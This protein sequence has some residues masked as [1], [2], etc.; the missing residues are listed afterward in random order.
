MSDRYYGRDSVLG[1]GVESTFGTAVTITNWLEPIEFTPTETVTNYQPQN[2]RR[3]GGFMI[4][5]PQVTKMEYT[6]SWSGEF[7][8][9]F[10]GML[11]EA[12]MGNAVSTSGAGPYVHVYDP[13]DAASEP[14]KFLTVEGG[15]GTSGNSVLYRGTCVN[16]FA[17]N[18]AP[19]ETVKY[20][21]DCIVQQANDAASEGT[22]TYGA[23]TYVNDAVDFV[24]ATWNGITLS[25][26]ELGSI[27]VTLNN[28]LQPSFALGSLYTNIPFYSGDGRQVEVVMDIQYA[29]T[30]GNALRD[31]NKAGTQSDL[32]IQYTSGAN[33]VLITVRNAFV[34]SNSIPAVADADDMRYSATFR[35]VSDTTDPA[36]T[37]QVTNASSS[38]I[39]NA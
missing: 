39:A 16:T 10:Q 37:I 34:D 36:I 38:G 33:D 24:S 19:N 9:D 3:L 7:C 6:L 29:A 11:L 15:L 27:T 2:L 14:A 31:G 23:L 25:D 1:L 17:L 5:G 32:V 12:A 30:I 13:A 8:Y 18:I 26:D 35:G 22:A 4:T 21:V 28:N 20:S